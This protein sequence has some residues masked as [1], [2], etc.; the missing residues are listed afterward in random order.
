MMHGQQ[1]VKSQTCVQLQ[2]IRKLS[3]LY[4]RDKCDSYN[5]CFAAIVS[6]MIRP[7]DGC[8]QGEADGG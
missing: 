4:K 6:H 5:K 8:K 3:V 7:W 2:V 1:N